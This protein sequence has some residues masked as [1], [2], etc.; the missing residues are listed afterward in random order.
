MELAKEKTVLANRQGILI[1]L[2]SR[3]FS[4][5]DDERKRIESCDDRDALDAAL[6]EMV[7]A[8]SRESVLAKLP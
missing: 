5:S 8:D 2:L 1:R 4:L 6:D 7:V 3:R